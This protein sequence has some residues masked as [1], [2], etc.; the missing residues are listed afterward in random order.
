MDAGPS[1]L[2]RRRRANVGD[3][4]V[5]YKPN[6][7]AAIVIV[8]TPDARTTI[9]TRRRV[10]HV[11]SAVGSSKAVYAMLAMHTKLVRFAGAG[12]ITTRFRD[13]ERPSFTFRVV[14]TAIHLAM[15][16]ASCVGTLPFNILEV[17]CECHI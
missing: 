16:R 8:I 6:S 12:K 5:P 11:Q 1:M 17:A 9:F 4:L 15:R 3:A 7:T 2:A 13:A 14:I 10:A